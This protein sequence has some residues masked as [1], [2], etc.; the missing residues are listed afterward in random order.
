MQHEVQGDNGAIHILRLTIKMQE[1]V[2][3][4]NGAICLEN[5]WSGGDAMSWP[6]QLPVY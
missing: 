4:G 5:N 6:L 2:Q 1:G 3:G